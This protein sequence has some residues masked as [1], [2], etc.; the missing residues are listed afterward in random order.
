[1]IVF[2]DRQCGIH[3][4]YCA[5]GII[6]FIILYGYL[7]HFLNRFLSDLPRFSQSEIVLSS[8]KGKGVQQLNDQ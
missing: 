1:M 5:I 7:L 4:L 6:D 2:I 8:L 3:M